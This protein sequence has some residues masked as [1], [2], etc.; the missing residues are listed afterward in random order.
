VL[1]IAQGVA[2]GE[3][4][5]GGLPAAAGD[6]SII[7]GGP[8]T[9]GGALTSIG[10]DPTNI[11]TNCGISTSQ[12]GGD[13]S[14]SLGCNS[15]SRGGARSTND[16]DCD[17][18]RLSEDNGTNADSGCTSKGGADNDEFDVGSSSIVSSGGCERDKA[19]EHQ[20]VSREGNVVTP[21]PLMPIMHANANRLIIND[22]WPYFKDTMLRN[23]ISKSH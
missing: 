15:R 22:M 10:G 19:Q 18:D 23:S 4:G 11:S 5:G 9:I 20:A 12:G 2:D 8:T 14:T 16:I 7:G 1:N 17:H 21:C 13:D 3:G 6:Q